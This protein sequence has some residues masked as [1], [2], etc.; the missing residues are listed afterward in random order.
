MTK[1][2]LIKELKSDIEKL[3]NKV[4]NTEMNRMFYVNRVVELKNKLALKDEIIKEY[5]SIEEQLDEF[6][7][8]LIDT[9]CPPIVLYKFREARKAK[10]KIEELES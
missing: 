7:G 1:E 8:W 6:G 5:E 4:K 9:K 10:K 3:S 2:E